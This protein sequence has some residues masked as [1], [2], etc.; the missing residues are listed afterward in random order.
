MPPSL[1]VIVPAY[2]EAAMVSALLQRVVDAPY[3]DK[4]IVVV[5]DGSTDGTAASLAPW[6]SVPGV[7]VLRHAVNRGKGAAVRTALPYA[8]GTVTLIQDADLEYDPNDYAKLVEPILKG[9]S[10]VVY[11]SRYIGRQ[12]LRW[13]RFRAGV[14]ALNLMVRLLYGCRLTDEATCY[15]AAPTWLWRSLSLEAERFELCA[16]V[17]AKVCRLN[18]PIREVPIRYIPRSVAEGKKIGWADVWPT[19]KMLIRWRFRTFHLGD[20]LNRPSADRARH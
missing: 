18:I 6:S 20:T 14:S 13:T 10:E 4:Q 19:I 7:V 2:N 8:V 3:V 9:G 15:K 11:G 16:E 5:D 17:T 1:T 12:R